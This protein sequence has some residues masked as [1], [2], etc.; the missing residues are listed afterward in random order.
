MHRAQAWEMAL[1]SIVLQYSVMRMVYGEYNLLD[2]SL[3]L[4]FNHFFFCAR[5][6]DGFAQSHEL[7]S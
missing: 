7:Y 5:A 4:V 3:H 1:L 2:A 6:S